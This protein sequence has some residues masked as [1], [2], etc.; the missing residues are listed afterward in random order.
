MQTVMFF[1]KSDYPTGKLKNAERYTC[2]VDGNMLIGVALIGELTQAED[3]NMWRA[4]RSEVSLCQ[5]ATADVAILAFGQAA[6]EIGYEVDEAYI[7]TMFANENDVTEADKDAALR[8][9]G[10]E[11]N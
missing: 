3:E 9:F 2:S 7:R 6:A 1:H 4:N 11:V 5:P 8:G 10:V